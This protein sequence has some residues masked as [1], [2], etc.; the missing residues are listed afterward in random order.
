MGTSGGQRLSSR[1]SGTSGIASSALVVLGG[2]WILVGP[3]PYG[4]AI[5]GA[6]HIVVTVAENG[7]S[8]TVNVSGWSWGS[9]YATGI[10][11]YG[12]VAVSAGSLLGE[13]VMQ[14]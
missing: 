10:L 7:Q 1:P 13:M 14:M 12:S 9:G 4:S 5:G 3:W 6:V 2:G 8:C 11:G